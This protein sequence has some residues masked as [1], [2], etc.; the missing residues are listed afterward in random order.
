MVLFWLGMYFKR[1]FFALYALIYLNIIQ[2]EI[3]TIQ[4]VLVLNF[5]FQGPSVKQRAL[6]WLGYLNWLKEK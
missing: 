6:H 1:G 4:N 2:Y 3:N 5:M